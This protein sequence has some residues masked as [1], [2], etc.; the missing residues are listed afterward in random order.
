MLE[1]EYDKDLVSSKERTM[2]EKQDKQPR[3]RKEER[4][5]KE[6]FAGSLSC[7]GQYETVGNVNY[8]IVFESWIYIAV[9]Y[10][11]VIKFALNFCGVF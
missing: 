4:R 6:I 11:E 2:S 10:R 7:D 5:S 8:F 1:E 3:Y 9:I